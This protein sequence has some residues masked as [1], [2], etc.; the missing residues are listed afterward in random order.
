[1]HLV[2]GCVKIKC[3]KVLHITA[4]GEPTLPEGGENLLGCTHIRLGYDL[5]QRDTAS[6]I[7]YQRAVFPFIMDQLSGILFHMHLVYPNGFFAV[8][9]CDLQMSIVTD[10][11]I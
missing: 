3:E 9:C 4:G 10:R 8:F 11:Q 1:M 2:E 7:I 6:I 5:D